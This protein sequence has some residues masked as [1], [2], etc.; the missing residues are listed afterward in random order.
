MGGAHD[1]IPPLKYENK[2]AKKDCFIGSKF[3]FHNI[4]LL[5]M[6]FWLILFQLLKEVLKYFKN[7]RDVFDIALT[8]NDTFILYE[9]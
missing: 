7:Q 4:I 5:S 6:F 1:N 8:T 2:M 3:Q 9:S